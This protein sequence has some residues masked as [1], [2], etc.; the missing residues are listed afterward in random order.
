MKRSALAIDHGERRCGFAVTD[1]LRL[2]TTPLSA[3]RDDANG[4]GLF[5]TIAALLD[6]RDVDS[7]VIGLPY[8]MDGSEG[9][10][11]AEVRAFATQLGARFPRVAIVFVDERLS[12]KAAEDLMRDAQIPVRDRKAHKDSFSALVLLRDWI[13]AGEPS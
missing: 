13:E 6:E 7:F 3:W 11:A 8:N 2:A 5:D 10:R 4:P 12:T 1:P 9:S